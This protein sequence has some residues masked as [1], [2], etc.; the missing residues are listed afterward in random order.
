VKPEATILEAMRTINEGGQAVAFVCGGRG[1]VHG[2]LTDGDL[3]RALLDGAALD[4]RCLMQVMRR[5]FARVTTGAGRAEALDTMRSR[6]IEQLPVLDERG[7]LVG[8]HTLHDLLGARQRPNI[9]VIMAGGR[10]TRLYPITR[11]LPKPMV[12]VAGRPILERLVLHLVGHGIQRIYL[13]VNYLGEMIEAHFGTGSAFGCEIRYLRE[14]TAL[15]TG[16]PLAL[17][18][19][20]PVEP[21]LVMNGDLVTQADIGRM[22]DFHERGRFVATMGLRTYTVEVPF[23]VASV[24]DHRVIALREKP[25]ER[26]AVNAGIYVLDA[27]LLDLIPP[28]CEFPITE[29]FGG[30]LKR[31]MAVGAHMIEDEWADVGRPQELQQARGIG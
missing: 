5:D 3:R 14:T 20:R 23:G 26:M 13:S 21:L 28:D 12:T 18:P 11:N 22:L 30:C 17:L 31:R 29:L 10:G 25:T 15:G 19:E 1:R 4:S 9:A 7:R 27:A 8:L 24:R 16:G 2:L 6:H